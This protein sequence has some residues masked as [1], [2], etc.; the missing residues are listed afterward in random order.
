MINWS[1]TVFVFVLPQYLKE[2]PEKIVFHNACTHAQ[3]LLVNAAVVSKYLGSNCNQ[4]WTAYLF[5]Q[6]KLM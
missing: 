2:V 5:F 4:R 6:I 3:C 1:Y